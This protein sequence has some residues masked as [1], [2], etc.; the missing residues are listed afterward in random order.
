M[1]LD[2]CNQKG[3]IKKTRIDKELIKSLIE[4]SNIKEIAVTS[5]EINEINISAYVSLAYDSLRE[6][7]E[8]ICISRG[9]KVLSHLCLGELLK[10]LLTDFDY[11]G[12]D[13]LRYIRNGINY[14]GIKV[15]FAQGKEIIKKAFNIKKRLLEKYLN[16]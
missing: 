9:Y 4:M 15:E 11:N 1:D 3:F 7:L 12:F 13:R 5:A 10:T 6:I 2:E 16:F 14:Y 8:A